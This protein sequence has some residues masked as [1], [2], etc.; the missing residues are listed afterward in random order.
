MLKSQ[1]NFALPID[2]LLLNIETWIKWFSARLTHWFLGDAA[3]SAMYKQILGTDVSSISYESWNCHQVD[4]TQPYW[5][6]I[7]GIFGNGLVPWKGYYPKYRCPSSIIPNGIV[8][9]QWDNLYV[10]W[11]S[12]AM[13]WHKSESTSAQVMACYLTAPSHYR[14]QCWLVIGEV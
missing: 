13:W 11:P 12:D 2:T 5:W 4:V 14:N 10:M 3:V 6:Y 1:I 7:T 8:T 9:G